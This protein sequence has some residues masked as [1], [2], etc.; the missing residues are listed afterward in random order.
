MINR[1]A[2]PEENCVLLCRPIA[3]FD[4]QT[5]GWRKPTIEELRCERQKHVDRTEASI[6]AAAMYHES[7]GDSSRAPDVPG[8]GFLWGKLA[9]ESTRNGKEN[10]APTQASF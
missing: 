3:R 2:L 5:G 6:N 10:A 1:N 4:V 8:Q 9:V 7:I